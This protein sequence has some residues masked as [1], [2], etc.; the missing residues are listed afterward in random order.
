MLD[1]PILTFL[2]LTF[3]L[4]FLLF[5]ISNYFKSGRGLGFNIS[6]VLSA[7]IVFLLFIGGLPNYINFDYN[8]NVITFDNQ[9]GQYY[10]AY[11]NGNDPENLKIISEFPNIRKAVLIEF[12]SKGESISW[13]N[14]L[15]SQYRANPNDNPI[16][17]L[18]IINRHLEETDV[19][20]T[21]GGGDGITGYVEKADLL[22]GD[23]QSKTLSEKYEIIANPPSEGSTSNCNMAVMHGDV[24]KE[25]KNRLTSP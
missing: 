13:T 7:I 11:L 12:N 3:L 22:I 16:T 19:L 21:C 23:W 1:F 14:D 6:F 24:F 10:G 25:I 17:V 5:F 18:L 9:I 8:P 20:Y 4:T 15:P 2:I